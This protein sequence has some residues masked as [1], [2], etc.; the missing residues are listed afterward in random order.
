MPPPP[1]PGML[2]SER[3]HGHLLRC[4][5]GYPV[6]PVALDVFC[7]DHCW[8][9]RPLSLNG[10][11]WTQ[12]RNGLCCQ[13]CIPRAAG[14]E[15]LKPVLWRLPHPMPLQPD[16]APGQARV[17]QLTRTHQTP[18][19]DWLSPLLKGA[20]WAF[21]KDGHS[22]CLLGLYYSLP[23]K[24]ATGIQVHL[25]YRETEAGGRWQPIAWDHIWETHSLGRI[26]CVPPSLT[27]GQMSLTD[28]LFAHA[29]TP[30]WNIPPLPHSHP[31][32]ANSDPI[33]QLAMP[34]PRSLPCPQVELEASRA[35]SPPP[36][37]PVASCIPWI[38]RP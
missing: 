31:H 3:P 11:P 26:L 27:L 20:H 19:Q 6:F 34:P 10:S 15:F 23:E 5:L 7:V 14:R 12:G 13:E 30:A 1:A 4:S 36:L 38:K 35:P 32:L 37:L 29:L 28:L 8:A 17:G 33:P 9:Q 2:L 22:S 18:A 25:T 16:H 21:P 24:A